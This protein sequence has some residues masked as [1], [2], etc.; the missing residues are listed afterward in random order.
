MSAEESDAVNAGGQRAVVGGSDALHARALE[1]LPGANTRTTLYVAPHPPYARSG[2][3]WT[4]RDE[5]GHELIDLQNNYTALIHGHAHP[6][7]TAAAVAAIRDGSAF[8]LPTRHEIALAAELGARVPAGERWRFANSGTEAVMIAIRA[9]RAHTGRDAI[10]RFDGAYHGSY[11]AVAPT[12]A[13]GVPASVAAD[14]V[15]SP[16]GDAEALRRALDVH[17]ERLAAVVFDLMPNRAGLRPAD[18]AYVELLCAETQ[19]RGI[20]LICDEV[21]TFRVG[22]SGAHGRYGL[23]PDLVTLGKLIGGGFPVGAVGGREDV[24]AAFD[25]RRPGAVGHG[26]TFSANPVTLRAGLAA[27]E[28][29]DE[30]EIERLNGLGDGLRA[31][32]AAQGWT[33]TG[34]GSLLRIH[35][36]DP[37]AVWWRLYAEGVLIAV[38]GLACLSTPMDAAVVARVE[39]A[40]A[41]AAQGS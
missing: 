20:L 10:L 25:P 37:A 39:A 3:G 14:V 30:G 19:R 23:R 2:T 26:G 12:G 41:R 16:I 35:A 1:H 31:A 18:P 15:V 34:L 27:L 33:V 21:L 4:V 36:S 13:P 22:L 5:D 6:A 38:N 7:V 32:L 29:W 8:G 17:G 9:A 40:F 28:A 24:M 11:D